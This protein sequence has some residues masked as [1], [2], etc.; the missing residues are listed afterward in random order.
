[1]SHLPFT[2]YFVIYELLLSSY[3]SPLSMYKNYKAE[4]EVNSFVYSGNAS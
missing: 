2:E 1:M 4:Q 3:R